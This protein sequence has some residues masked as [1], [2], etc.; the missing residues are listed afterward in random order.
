MNRY[1]VTPVPN[2]KTFNPISFT[3]PTGPG[4]GGLEE[5]PEGLGPR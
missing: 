1:V 3:A 5:K 2:R 4:M